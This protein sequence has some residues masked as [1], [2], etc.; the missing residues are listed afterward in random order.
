MI[1][2]ELRLFLVALR[3]LTRLPCP[4]WVGHRPQDAAGSILYF[5]AVGVLVGGIG[6]SVYLLVRQGYTAAVA[7][8]CGIAAVVVI[9]GAF[10]ED[11]FADV[12][13][14][15]GGW[16]PQRRL[17]IMRDSRLGAY[18][19][20]GLVLLIGLKALLLGG[21]AA[22]HAALAFVVAHTVAR[23]S[24]VIMLAAFP[25]VS[26]TNSL[27]RSFAGALSPLRLG[28]ASVI[29][30]CVCASAGPFPAF[31][32]LCLTLVL[33]AA[34][35]RFFLSWL[36]GVSGDCLGAVNQITELLCYFILTRS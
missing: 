18:G 2:E 34:A 25:T 14:G 10:H 29:A 1:R 13:D 30:V 4:E 17:E 21:M 19:V 15:F 8:L 3:F 32:I 22:G 9:T 35:G 27:A 11:A 5:P 23:W 16:T 7:A 20:V 28:L 31:L 24:S 36:G 33:C 26:G 12:C 6:G